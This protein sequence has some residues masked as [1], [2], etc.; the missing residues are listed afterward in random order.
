[1]VNLLPFLNKGLISSM[2]RA[3]LYCSYVKSVP[4]LLSH[5]VLSQLEEASE[6]NTTIFRIED[7][8]QRPVIR[9]ELTTS[10][11]RGLRTRQ[12]RF[13]LSS[14]YLYRH[15]YQD[16]AQSLNYC[17]ARSPLQPSSFQSSKDMA[18][19]QNYTDLREKE[20]II[21]S[22]QQSSGVAK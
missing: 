13:V 12:N 19:H 1:M 22:L 4:F 20:I 8:N 18:N 5:S 6:I 2:V 7:K 10:N 11:Y 21:T 16:K 9:N 3:V 17:W 15:F 14:T